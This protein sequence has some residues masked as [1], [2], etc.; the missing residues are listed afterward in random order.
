MD[1]IMDTQMQSPTF[2]KLWT[3]EELA[4]HLQ[5][6]KRWIYDRTRQAG[7][8][9]IPHTKLGKYIRFDPNSVQFQAW[10]KRHEVLPLIDTE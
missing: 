2:R 4:K 3:P 5:V 7:A 6:K 1:R 8:E 10:L 9:R